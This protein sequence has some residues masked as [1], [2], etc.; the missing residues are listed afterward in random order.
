MK[1]CVKEFSKQTREKGI[2]TAVYHLHL[3]KAVLDTGKQ[4]GEL[5]LQDFPW[6]TEFKASSKGLQ[7]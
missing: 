2:S 6:V 5:F 1:S 4:I 3:W 7:M